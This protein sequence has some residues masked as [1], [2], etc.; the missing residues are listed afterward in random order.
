V[1]ERFWRGDAARSG[2]ELHSGLGLSLVSKTA[3]ILGGHVGVQSR[4][5]RQFEITVVIPSQERPVKERPVG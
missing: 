1:F 4:A 2:T 3:A 5:G